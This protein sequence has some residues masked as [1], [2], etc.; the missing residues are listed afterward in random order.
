MTYHESR[1]GHDRPSQKGT[2]MNEHLSSQPA[3]PAGAAGASMYPPKPETEDM[4]DQVKAKAADALDRAKEQGGQ[5]VSAVEDTANQGIDRAAEAAQGL[6]ATIR[7]QAGKLPGDQASDLAYQAAGNL[8]R[9]AEY[10]R[11]T[12]VAEMRGDL[13][14]LIRRYPAQSL[15]VGLAAGFLV[16]RAFR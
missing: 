15:L 12:D 6:A 5:A 3:R 9:G 2:A 7:Q 1:A 11:Q 14:D 4:V 8:E 13:E 10:L 16:A